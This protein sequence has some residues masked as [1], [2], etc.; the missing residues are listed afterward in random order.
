MTDFLYEFKRREPVFQHPEFGITQQ[1]FEKLTDKNFYGVDGYGRRYSRKQA[2]TTAL[3]MYADPNYRGIYSWPAG[4]WEVGKFE[5]HAIAPNKYIVTYILH[6]RNQT[7][8]RTSLWRVVASDWTI[9]FHQATPI[10]P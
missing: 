9:M 5:W 8:R 4:T 6:T 2:I 1:A 10:Q 7:T 3:A